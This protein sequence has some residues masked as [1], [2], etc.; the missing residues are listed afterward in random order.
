MRILPTA[1]GREYEG[2]CAVA[3]SGEDRHTLKILQGL[4]RS[5]STAIAAQWNFP[6]PI[7]KRLSF[8]SIP[9]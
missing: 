3:K 2:A 6:V 1:C 8:L 5:E 9:L 4:N 7:E